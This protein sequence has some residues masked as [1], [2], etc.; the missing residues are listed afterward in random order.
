MTDQNRKADDHRRKAL[1]YLDQA[2]ATAN[3]DERQ[4]LITRCE[5][6]LAKAAAIRR[7]VEGTI[8]PKIDKLKG[9]P[10]R[11]EDQ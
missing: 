10:R 8:D 11:R 4:D 6:E 3:V 2:K 5:Q 1:K 7:G 9:G